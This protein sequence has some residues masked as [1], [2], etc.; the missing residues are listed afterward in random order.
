MIDKETLYKE[1]NIEMWND[2]KIADFRSLLLNWFEEDGRDLPFRHTKDPYKIWVSEIM[3]QQT[4]VVTVIPYWERFLDTLPTVKDLAEASEEVYLKLWEGLGYYSRVKNMHIAA[5]QIM[6]DFDGVFPDTR[7][8]LEKLK[9]IGPYTSGAIASIAF[10]ESVPAID[11]NAM[12]VYARLFEVDVDIAKAKN[13][14]IFEAIGSDLVD[15]NY[16]GEFNQA[17]MDLGASYESA[18][19]YHPEESPIKAYNASYLNGT[20]DYYPVKGK[21]KKAKPVT[22]IA[23]LI[24]NKKGEWLIQ[25]RPEKG[26]LANMWTFPLIEAETL[27]EASGRAFPK[28]SKKSPELTVNDMDVVEEV[29]SEEYHVQSKI[30]AESIGTIVHQFSHLKWTIHAYIV[31]GKDLK[32]L[33]ENAEWVEINDFDQYT[34][35]TVQH[36]LVNLLNN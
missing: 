24:Q 4:Q 22:Y 32:E 27:T 10:N 7:K 14:K 21:A 18:K 1:N 31:D 25:K 8:S 28:S 5:N 17:I 20:Y 9:G 36:K 19:N 26:L 11:G 2:E 15:P 16:P 6:D 13:R 33:P 29:L 23:T 30:E 34:F 35:P 12:R 3:L